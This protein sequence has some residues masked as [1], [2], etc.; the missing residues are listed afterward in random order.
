MSLLIYKCL[1]FQRGFM[2]RNPVWISF[3]GIM[4]LLTAFFCF[5]AVKGVWIWGAYSEKIEVKVLNWEIIQTKSGDLQPVL[6]YLR[7]EEGINKI[8]TSLYKNK[9]FRNEWAA[10]KFLDEV[11]NISAWPV[12]VRPNQWGDAKLTRSF[13]WKAVIYALFLLGILGYFIWLGVYVVKL[14]KNA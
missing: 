10:N 13:P 12:W 1:T 14:Q 6:S 11:K 2:H 9:L 5:T 3:L 7:S 4:V 8:F